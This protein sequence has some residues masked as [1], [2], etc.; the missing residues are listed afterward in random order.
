MK[1]TLI[2]WML[3]VVGVA[4]SPAAAVFAEDIPGEEPPEF[5]GNTA[6]TM[7]DLAAVNLEE[8]APEPEPEPELDPEL[9]E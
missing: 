4:L 8:P 9:A 5:A 1:K 7:F 2:V 6:V 3:F